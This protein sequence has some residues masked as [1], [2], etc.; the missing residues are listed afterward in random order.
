MNIIIVGAGKVGEYLC[1]DLSTEGYDITLI[2]KDKEILDRV[3][4]YN[5]ILGIQGDGANTYILEEAGIDRCDIFI[6]VT[7]E[8]ELNMVCC[9][10]AK[11][12][13]AK[14]TISR[15]RNPEYSSHVDFMSET[16]NIDLMINPELETARE[17]VR[18]LNFPDVYNVDTF[19]HGKINIVSFKIKIGSVLNN[20]TLNDLQNKISRNIL[21]GTVLRG[22][23]VFI[24]N[25][26]F[27]LKENDLIYVIGE[28]D[29]LNE[30][31]NF[32]GRS[33]KNKNIMIIGGG[34]IAFYLIGR[35]IK[36]NFNVKVI[37]RNKKIAENLSFTFPDA[38]IIKEDGTNLDILEEERI[39]NFDTFISLTGIDE[40][41]ILAS[42]FASKKGVK[43]TITKVDR[44]RILEML[45][46]EQI[47]MTISPKR[48]ISDKIVKFIRTNLS[49]KNAKIETFYRIADDKVEAI[50][51][52]IDT[53]LN[54][55]NT[56]LKDID[57]KDDTLIAFI[58]RENKLIIPNG[59]VELKLN[60][61][62]LIITLNK[63]VA[64]IEDLIKK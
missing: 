17:I 13:G 62:V 31:F 26:D 48:V 59:D 47:G 51:F 23:E 55:L 25:G 20:L 7:N 11:K 52:D 45:E 63:S 32:V 49:I 39:K 28:N 18:T 10:M 35:L 9:V 12:L 38:D 44:T 57:V 6:A 19:A 2:E 21:I 43:R 24:P 27:I 4:D 61:K 40:E 54:I 30:F 60:D 29:A 42:V 14:H 64:K 50:E 46:I 3:L 22:T 56:P 5:D 37:E 33:K 53:D 16:M 58:I 15:V 41:N 34:R 8:D 36:H 1:Q